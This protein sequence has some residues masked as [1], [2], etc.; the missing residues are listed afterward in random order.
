MRTDGMGNPLERFDVI[1]YGGRGGSS[2]FQ[3]FA[4]VL[5]QTPAGN[6]QVVAPGQKFR[7]FEDGKPVWEPVMAKTTLTASV[8]MCAKVHPD[9]VSDEWAGYVD[10][11]FDTYGS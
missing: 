3:S 10:Q 7:G 9:L 4:I 6:L 5:G 2:G 11:A 1:H 8:E